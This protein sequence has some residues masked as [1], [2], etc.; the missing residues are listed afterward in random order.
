MNFLIGERLPIILLKEYELK[1]HIKGHLAYTMKWNPTL[2]E[3]LKAQLEPE[4]NL[5]NLQLHLKNA[6]LWF[7]IYQNEK[8]ADFQKLFHFFFVEVWKLLQSWSY[9][10]SEPWRWGRTTNTLETPFYWRYKINWKVKRYFTDVIINISFSF[11]FLPFFDHKRMKVR[12][13]EHIFA[14]DG[15]NRSD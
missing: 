9:W 10:E 7:G 15:I 11:Y 14:R 13:K 12:I 8:M 1:S 5:T 2:R 4:M 6:M 3:F